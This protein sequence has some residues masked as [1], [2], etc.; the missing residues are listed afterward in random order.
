[1]ILRVSSVALLSATLLSLNA[2]KPGFK[3]TE[4]GLEYNIVKDAKGTEKPAIGDVV[5]MNLYI[6][7][8]DSVLFDS[9]KMNNGQPIQ[10]PLPAP[11]F[12]GD[13]SEGFMMMTAGDSA[14]FRIAIDSLKK[15]GAQLLPWMKEGQKIEYNVAMVSVKSSA[16]M[17]EEQA[18]HS[19]EQKAK[20][21]TML[22][23]YLNKNGI[24][25]N[26]T[27]SGLYYKMDKEGTGKMAEAGS[28][29]TVNYT[30]KT[31]DGT[32]FDSNVDP[33]FKHTEP[34]TF[35]LGRGQV[36]PGWDEG[37]GLMK[38]GSKGKLFIPSTLAYGE[39]SPN[40]AIPKDA[41]LIFDIEVTKVADAP[42]AQTQTIQ[43]Q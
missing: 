22:Q 33:Q 12:K 31:I 16:K 13:I 43:A 23:E 14:I 6:H 37:V 21:E 27:A 29:V 4:T 30:G 10:F 8:G 41:I 15:T 36:I 18:A 42:P 39:N 7:V 25:A 2:C 9:R 38:E 34:F 19:S 35:M 11:S 28:M 40:P 26:K 24:T 1:M 5:E 3:K 20:D 32:T 17:K